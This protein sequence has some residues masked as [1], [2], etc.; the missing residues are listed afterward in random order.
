[1]F[2]IIDCVYYVNCMGKYC[3]DI[4]FSW[5]EMCLKLYIEF[6]GRCDLINGMF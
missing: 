6:G 3:S 2:M 5:G 4:L 1:M